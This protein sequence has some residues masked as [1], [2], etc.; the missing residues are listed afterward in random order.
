MK[1]LKII[2]MF[3]LSLVIMGIA[4][5]I[6][7]LFDS[8]IPFLRGTIFFAFMYVIFAY[9]A[10]KFVV[11]RVLSGVLES[12]RITLPRF[13]KIYVILGFMLPIVVY[14][15]YVIFV[16]GEFLIQKLEFSQD[17]LRNI[18][19]AIFVNGFAAAIVEEMVCR[20]LLMGYVEKKTNIY[21]AV[22]SSA[23]FFALI[24]L[25]NGGL[26]TISFCMLLISG[27]LVGLMFGMAT[28]IFNT[29]WAS[30]TLHFLWNISQLL[31]I[32]GK[33]SND[34]PFQYILH[35]QSILLTGGEFGIE[36]SIIST[37]GYS[38]VIL[39][40]LIIHRRKAI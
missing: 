34:Q 1:Y 20:G 2:G 36:S 32:S 16:P 33:A 5:G 12:Y 18:F 29:I 3:M 9:I 15:T 8:L 11:T 4:Q 27:T 25:L 39:I 40:L 13:N 31:F 35:N 19:W 6:A 38:M 14:S 24:H 10:V 23:L 21:I 26:N 7:Q 30:I 28:Y 37:V 17:Y 22:V